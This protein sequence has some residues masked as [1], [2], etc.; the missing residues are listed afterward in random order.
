[1]KKYREFSKLSRFKRYEL[2][3]NETNR[4][5]RFRM[6]FG[7]TD[8]QTAAI[9]NINIKSVR[10]YTKGQ[11]KPDYRVSLAMKRYY[12]EKMLELIDEIETSY[13]ALVNQHE[14]FKER[15]NENG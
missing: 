2:L 10:V 13:P 15:I 8:H 3:K 11:R 7:L 1:M 14:F 6:H 9:L 4:F 5:I 12:A